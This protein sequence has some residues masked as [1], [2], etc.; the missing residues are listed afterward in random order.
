MTDKANKI[1]VEKL[2]KAEYDQAK[3]DI[4][5]ANEI[6]SIYENT[7]VKTEDEEIDEVL[8]N[9][10]KQLEEYEWVTDTIIRV[11]K[12]AYLFNGKKVEKTLEYLNK[13]DSDNVFAISK[14]NKKLVK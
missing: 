8:L 11:N 5:R 14:L 3:R 10:E 2:T 13:V 6:I 12:V 1:E 7:I 9:G 4:E